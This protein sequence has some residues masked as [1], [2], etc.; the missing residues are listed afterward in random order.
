MNGPD[1]NYTQPGNNSYQ[2]AP[3]KKME[4]NGLSPQIQIAVNLLQKEAD[5]WESAYK[6]SEEKREKLETEL[7]T[8]RTESRDKDHRQALQ[9]IEDKKPSGLERFMDAFAKTPAPILDSLAP[10]IGALGNLIP[11]PKSLQGVDGQLDDITMDVVKWMQTK[12]AEFNQQLYAILN[13]IARQPDAEQTVS[14]TKLYNLLTAT[15]TANVITRPKA[16]GQYSSSMQ[17]FG[18]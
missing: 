1:N 16:A 11:K 12:P 17:I 7:Q 14:L 10:I 5:R 2:P 9:G 8:L 18:T 4:I 13:V 6:K 3:V 15:P